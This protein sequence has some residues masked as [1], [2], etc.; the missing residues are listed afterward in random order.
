M[1]RASPVHQTAMFVVQQPPVIHV[2]PPMSRIA[3]ANV[4]KIVPMVISIILGRAS[5]AHHT[6]MFVVQHPHVLHVQKT[7]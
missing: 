7:M 1:G 4:L 6:V 5:P 3:T 2:H